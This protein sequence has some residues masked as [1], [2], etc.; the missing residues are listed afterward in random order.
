LTAIALC[1][2]KHAIGFFTAI[3]QRGSMAK[4]LAKM[5]PAR[6]HSIMETA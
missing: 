5:P 3:R 6:T 1:D 2:G 4:N